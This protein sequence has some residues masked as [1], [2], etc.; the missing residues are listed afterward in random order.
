MRLTHDDAQVIVD[1]AGECLAAYDR[2]RNEI[3]TRIAFEPEALR[4]DLHVIMDSISTA[5]SRAAT[6]AIEIERDFYRRHGPRIAKQREATRTCRARVAGRNPLDFGQGNGPAEPYPARRK[7][8][9]ETPAA[10]IARLAS[11]ERA[12]TEREASALARAQAATTE[13]HTP[14][15]AGHESAKDRLEF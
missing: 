8:G 13:L 2:L 4:V 5:P 7:R 3:G 10:E 11:E 14:D 12:W 15:L 1:A 6:A 9:A